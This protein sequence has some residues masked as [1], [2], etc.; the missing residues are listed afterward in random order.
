L[1]HCQLAQFAINQRQKM[2]GRLDIAFLDGRKDA[3]DFAH[4]QHPD[5]SWRYRQK[6]TALRDDPPVCNVIPWM[7]ACEPDEP[8][9]ELWNR[10]LVN[11]LGSQM[12]GSA[13]SGLLVI[14]SR[15][16]DFAIGYV[17]RNLSCETSPQI[18]VFPSIPSSDAE[19]GITSARIPLPTP[20]DT[21]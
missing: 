3:S 7:E 2:L 18:P 5:C 15:R 1:L 20:K 17:K 11:G 8:V 12:A 6:Y 13:K 21:G 9:R 10:Y 14:D 16:I 4:R 19:D